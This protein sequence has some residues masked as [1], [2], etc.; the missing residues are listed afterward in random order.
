M[1]LQHLSPR[2]IGSVLG[3]LMMAGAAVAPHRLETERF[4]DAATTV[5][6]IPLPPTDP[7]VPKK[8][9]SASTAIPESARATMRAQAPMLEAVAAIQE[10]AMAKGHA[11]FAGTSLKGDGLVLYWKG[12]VPTEISAALAGYRMQ[13]AIELKDAPYSAAELAAEAQRMSKLSGVTG[14]GALS[15]FSGLWVGVDSADLARFGPTIQAESSMKLV[16]RVQAAVAPAAWRWDDTD[17]F[18]G[19]SVVEHR[20]GIWPFFSYSYCTTGFAARRNSDNVEALTLSNHC[21]ANA[22]WHTPNSGLPL[23]NTNSGVP[24]ADS[25]YISGQDYGASVYVGPYTSGSGVTINGYVLPSEGTL[26]CYEGG[27]SGA[28]CNSYITD[29]LVYID[30][31]GGP[32]F[33]SEDAGH[34]AAAGEG[35]S[36][37]PVL[38]GSTGSGLN[39]I[40]V[41]TAIDTGTAATCQGLGDRQCAWHVFSINLIAALV[42]Q[43]LTLQTVP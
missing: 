21:G 32:G 3:I 34:V 36:G 15:D 18:W 14:A 2:V 39:G 31:I 27:F 41:I 28:S 33:W 8:D 43:N 24:G 22:D 30:G 13:F 10:L 35:D 38:A 19:G 1:T 25:N 4:A 5:K 40:G 11:G 37:G 12:A 23:G 42:Q 29:T 16:P 17:P 20:S 7:S 9:V 6:R 26:V